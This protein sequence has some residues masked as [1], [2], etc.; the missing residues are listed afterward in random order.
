MKKGDKFFVRID[1][2]IEGTEVKKE[3]FEDHLAYLK[4]AAEERYFLGGGF[5]N[6]PGGMIVF[7]AIDIEEAKLISEGDPLIKKGL[8]TY[9]LLEWELA[10]VSE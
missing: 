2:K 10:L 4:K 6:R 7:G 9:E 1:H 3:D 8:Y 5:E